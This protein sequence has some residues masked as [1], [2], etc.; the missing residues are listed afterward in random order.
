MI[1][2]LNYFTVSSPKS[3]L[4]G[5]GNIQGVMRCGG[6]GTQTMTCCQM[7]GCCDVEHFHSSEILP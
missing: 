5:R 7:L 2:H 6:N 3:Q 4:I 1:V